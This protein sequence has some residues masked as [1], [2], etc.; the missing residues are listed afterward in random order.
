[1]IVIPRLK[2][3]LLFITFLAYAEQGTMTTDDT[4]SSQAEASLSGTGEEENMDLR[5]EEVQLQEGPTEEIM[6]E[7]ATPPLPRE[8]P[9]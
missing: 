9:Q 8:E 4:E 5:V 2:F 1:M 6:P 7:S 3:L